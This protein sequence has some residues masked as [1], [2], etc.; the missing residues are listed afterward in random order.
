MDGEKKS[1]LEL[2]HTEIGR[3]RL[4]EP[5]GEKVRSLLLNRLSSRCLL[6]EI[7]SNFGKDLGK[8]N[9]FESH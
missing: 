8:R 4:G 2:S 9:K 5:K 1:Q 6:H 7:M 3:L